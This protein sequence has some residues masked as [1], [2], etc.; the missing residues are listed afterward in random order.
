MAGRVELALPALL[1]FVRQLGG[2]DDDVDVASALRV[3]A[4]YLE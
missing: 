2:G 4:A 3:H 1:K